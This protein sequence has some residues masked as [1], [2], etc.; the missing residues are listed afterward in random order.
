MFRTGSAGCRQ[1]QTA[2]AGCECS[3]QRSL[4]AFLP[5][6]SAITPKPG[7]QAD[8]A[9]AASWQEQ[10]QAQ[11][12]QVSA[13][14]GVGWG[15]REGLEVGECSEVAGLSWG[16]LQAVH[17][18]APALHPPGQRGAGHAEA[19]PGHA[20]HTRHAGGRRARCGAAGAA[21]SGPEAGG[22]QVAAL[23]G[24]TAPHLHIMQHHTTRMHS[25]NPDSFLTPP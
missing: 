14:G 6:P 17:R 19:G 15:W 4:L 25:C 21:A 11:A 12:R 22:Q 8:P 2:H 18:H 13:W 3:A 24:W 1:P 20:Q 9:A 10:W 23:L 7:L 5:A 16:H